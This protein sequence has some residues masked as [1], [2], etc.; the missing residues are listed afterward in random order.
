MTLQLDFKTK[1]SMIIWV[2]SNSRNL[3]IE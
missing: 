3:N 2:L 1:Q